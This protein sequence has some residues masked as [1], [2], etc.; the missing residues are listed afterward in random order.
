MPI[1]KLPAEAHRELLTLLAAQE[2]AAQRAQS[3]YRGCCLMIGLQPDDPRL[4]LNTQVGQFELPD[5]PAAIDPSSADPPAA[6]SPAA[7][8][9]SDNGSAV[10]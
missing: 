9:P 2:S 4:R 1:H 7:V 3:F 6:A 5:P 8:L 10:P